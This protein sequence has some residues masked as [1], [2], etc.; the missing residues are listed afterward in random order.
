MQVSGDAMIFRN[1][2]EGATGKFY[3]YSM[4]VSGK[5]QDGSW[6]N[7]YMDIRFKKGVV[8]EN[9]TKINIT[10][11][12]LTAREYVA[13]GETVKKPEIMVLDFEVKSGDEAGYTAMSFD[14]VPF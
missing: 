11:G 7:A 2:R 5:K 10:N 3:T 4:G 14:D 8:L 13:N 12:F 9:K 6:V 1:E